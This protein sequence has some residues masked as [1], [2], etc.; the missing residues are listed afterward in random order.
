M[1]RILH[2]KC[3]R[4]VFMLELLTYQKSNE[5]AQRTS[6]IYVI[7]KQ[8]VRM[9]R[10]P[11]L[12]MCYCVYYIHTE[13]YSPKSYV[14]NLHTKMSSSLEEERAIFSTREKKKAIRPIR[15]ANDVFFTCKKN[16]TS[17][18]Q[19]SQ[20]CVSFATKFPPFIER[21]HMTSR[22]HESTRKVFPEEFLS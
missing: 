20:R 1:H 5:W 22:R 21:F 19:K 18:D 7:Q 17:H 10:T 15:I 8:R 4:T 3:G 14:V 13:K 2:R 6:E 12:S 16:D 11:A 9:Y